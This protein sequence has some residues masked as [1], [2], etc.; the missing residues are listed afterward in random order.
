MLFVSPWG[1]LVFDC[2]ILRGVAENIEVAMRSGERR[3]P[4]RPTASIVKI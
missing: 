1:N 2:D 4:D 3:G